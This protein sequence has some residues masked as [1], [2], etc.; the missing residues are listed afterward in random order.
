MSRGTHRDEKPP[1]YLV[2][3]RCG[4]PRARRIA[5]GPS[6]Q[7]VCLQARGPCGFLWERAD[8]V[9]LFQRTRMLPNGR[10]HPHLSPEGVERHGH[11]VEIFQP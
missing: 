11:V 6:F 4:S 2:C 5:I 9:R 3:C 1:L 7:Y 8:G 10:E